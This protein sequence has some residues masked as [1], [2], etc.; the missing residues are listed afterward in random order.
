MFMS[1]PRSFFIYVV[2]ALFTLAGGNNHFLLAQD[3]TGESDDLVGGAGTLG[4]QPVRRQHH[5]RREKQTAAASTQPTPAQ[6]ASRAPRQTARAPKRKT[7]ETARRET[8]R[9]RET[10]TREPAATR[11]PQPVKPEPDA[12]AFNDQGDQLFDA[13]QY[14]RAIDAYKQAVRLKPDYAE[15]YNSLGDAYF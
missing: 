7:A 4:E 13:G 12:A 11:P 15:A 8:A 10:P 14:D 3:I 9:T 5:P 1:P 2:L 6:A